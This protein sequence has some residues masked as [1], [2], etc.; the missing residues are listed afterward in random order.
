VKIKL[1]WKDECPK[2]PEAKA[3]LDG[4]PNV[5]LYNLNDLDGLSEGA[6]YGIMAT[7]SI[8]VVDDLGKEITSFRGTV[9]SR[10]QMAEWIVH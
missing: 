5:E 4:A 8:I 9:P 7:P 2:C 3:L 6:F 1:F 10:N